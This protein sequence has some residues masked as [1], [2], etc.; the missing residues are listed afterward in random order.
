MAA[1]EDQVQ[2]DSGLSER[3]GTENVRENEDCSSFIA[4]HFNSPGRRIVTQFRPVARVLVSFWKTEDGTSCAFPERL[5]DAFG[6]CSRCYCRNGGYGRDADAA[7]A[8]LSRGEGRLQSWFWEIW[9]C[10]VAKVNLLH[11]AGLDLPM[12]RRRLAV[13]VTRVID[14]QKV[15][16]VVEHVPRF[17][18]EAYM[19]TTTT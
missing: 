1:R 14:S 19:T 15:M 3:Q 12:D 9:P 2:I 17:V 16:T 6:R 5:L 10:N 4:D 11:E 8:P 18:R 7:F 13:I